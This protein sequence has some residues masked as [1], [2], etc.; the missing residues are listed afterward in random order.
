MSDISQRLLLNR[1]VILSISLPRQLWQLC[2]RSD[3][4]EDC[5]GGSSGAHI[6]ENERFKKG[7]WGKLDGPYKVIESGHW[8][9]ITKPDEL[10]EDILILSS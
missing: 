7:K 5:G 4:R 3:A 2:M 8:P 1:A 6:H 10:I 9:M